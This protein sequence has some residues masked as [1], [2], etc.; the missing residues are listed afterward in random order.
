MFVSIQEVTCSHSSIASLFFAPHANG[1]H[2]ALCL[3]NYRRSGTQNFS[4][5]PLV[6]TS[7]RIELSNKTSNGKPL[8]STYPLSQPATLSQPSTP[9][10]PTSQA[11]TISNLAIS[12]QTSEAEIIWILKMV[13]SNM[14]FRSCDNFIQV[15]QRMLPG[16]QTLQQMSLGRDKASYSVQFGLAPYFHDRLMDCVNKAPVYVVCF[17]ESLNKVTQEK[18]MDCHVR[19]YDCATY[20]VT[21]RFIT[22]FFRYRWMVQTLI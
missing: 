19:Y 5:T 11:V 9:A 8:T 2:V 13:M 14:S 22:S 12:R 1:S 4:T 21:T 17:D 7:G 20:Q 16:T 6:R 3:E 10:C 15:L 18:Q